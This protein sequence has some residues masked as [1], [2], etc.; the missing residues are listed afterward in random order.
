MCIHGNY[1]L[2]REYAESIYLSIDRSIYL[3][4]L[5]LHFQ[6]YCFSIFNVS[7]YLKSILIFQYFCGE[8]FF[9]FMWM[10][11]S[12]VSKLAGYIR[13]H[14]GCLH[15][16]LDF[17]VI[18]NTRGVYAWYGSIIECGTE[19]PWYQNVFETYCMISFNQNSSRRAPHGSP[20]KRNPTSAAVLVEVLPLF[21]IRPPPSISTSL[22]PATQP[23]VRPATFLH[24][25]PELTV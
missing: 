17:D 10:W 2:D 1:V 23:G 8:V 7:F 5:T 13:S 18:K 4:I 3:F 16:C 6:G 19:T 12:A 20:R 24:R 9:Y 22:Q 15:H 25:S 14:R 11:R 21:S